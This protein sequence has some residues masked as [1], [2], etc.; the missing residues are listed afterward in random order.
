MIFSSNQIVCGIKCSE[1]IKI[2]ALSGFK[3]VGKTRNNHRCP[4]IPIQRNITRLVLNSL[5]TLGTM[6][7]FNATF[8]FG[9]GSDH[10]TAQVET[11]C[12]CLCYCNVQIGTL[13]S[14]RSHDTNITGNSTAQKLKITLT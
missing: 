3:I 14:I 5:M 10:L 2:E 1:K 8:C 13:D 6:S 12:V 9:L 4:F 7:I 11:M